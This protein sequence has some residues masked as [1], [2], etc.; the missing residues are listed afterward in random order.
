MLRDREIREPLFGY[1]EER[2]GKVRILEEMCMGNS[3][4]DLLM[5]TPDALYGLEIKSDADTY[6]RLARQVR[7]YDLFCDYNLAVIGT[8]HAMQIHKHIPGHWGILTVEEVN[9]MPDFYLLR[10]P[11]RNP[12][13]EWTRKLS[14]LWKPELAQ[15]Q[16][17]NDMPKYKEKS[18]RFV[19]QKITELLPEQVSEESLRTQV[20]EILF[21]RDYTNAAELLAEYRK[22]ELQK[23]MEAESDPVCR[24]EL[25]MEQAKKRKQFGRGKGKR[26]RRI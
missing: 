16:E 9:G 10:R 5:V 23:R 8:S 21:E 18:R 6:A 1:L 22:G 7:D 11:Q 26:R 17:W 24:M 14:L 3:R 15:I 2:Y 20:S 25:M 13:M 4:A 19:V 12:N